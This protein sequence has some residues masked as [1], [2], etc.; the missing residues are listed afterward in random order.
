MGRL[1][2]EQKQKLKQRRSVSDSDWS[3]PLRYLERAERTIGLGVGTLAAATPLGA[4]ANLIPGVRDWIPDVQNIPEAVGSFWEQAR[5]GDWDAGIE[6]YQDELDAGAGYWGLSELAGAFIP[7]GGPALAGAKL[8]SAAPKIGSGFAKFAPVATREAIERA[9]T[10]AATRT[11]QVLRA[12]WEAEE[13]VGRAAVEGITRLIKGKRAAP[14]TAPDELTGLFPDEEGP[15]IFAPA[16]QRDPIRRPPRGEEIP[17]LEGTFPEGTRLT[18]EGIVLDAEGFP[19]GYI[20]E[21][22]NEFIS[23]QVFRGQRDRYGLRGMGP[24]FGYKGPQPGVKNIEQRTDQELL[25]WMESKGMSPRIPGGD[26]KRLAREARADRP[27]KTGKK[28]LL[29]RI[30]FEV[31]RGGLSEDVAEAAEEWIELLPEEYLEDLASSF[32]QMIPTDQE[33][34]VVLGRLNIGQPSLFYGGRGPSILEIGK[35]MSNMADQADRV[36]IHEIVHHLEEYVSSA[37][38]RKLVSAWQKEQ[39]TKGQSVLNKVKEIREKRRRTEEATGK[40]V[41]YTQSEKDIIAQEYRYQGDFAEWFAEVLTDKALRDIY[42]EVPV[43]KNVIE[44]VLAQIKIMAKA[45]RE[46][47]SKVLGRND[48]AEDV[49]Q[50]LMRGDY[51]VEERRFFGRGDLDTDEWFDA[52]ATRNLS[53]DPS[54]IGR[55]SS[56]RGALDPLYRAPITAGARAA[57]TE[58]ARFASSLSGIDTIGASLDEGTA[59]VVD[60]AEW[61]ADIVAARNEAFDTNFEPRDFTTEESFQALKASN[62]QHW[63]VSPVCVNLSAAKAG[64]KLDPNDIAIGKAVVRAIDEIRPPSISLENVPDYTKTTLFKDITDALDRAGYSWDTNVVEAADYGAASTRKRLILRAVLPEAG[65]LPPLPQKTHAFSETGQGVD[66]YETLTDLIQVEIDGGRGLPIS[67]AF[68][69]KTPGQVNDELSRI[70]KTFQRKEGDRLRLNPN[71]PIL[72]MGGSASKGIPSARNAGNP[73]PTLMSTDRAVPRIILPGPGGFSD[74]TVIRVT[75]EMMQRL[76]GIPEGFK[77]PAAPR[78][79]KTT[80]GNGVHGAVTKGFIQPLVDI[81]RAAPQPGRQLGA[82]PRYLKARVEDIA[83]VEPSGRITG[84]IRRGTTLDPEMSQRMRATLGQ[85]S[86]LSRWDKAKN[87]FLE[88]GGK[89]P[90]TAARTGA[91]KA[92]M[93]TKREIEQQITSHASRVTATVRNGKRVFGAL[94]ENGRILDPA[95]YKQANVVLAE[96]GE[97]YYLSTINRPTIQ[98]VAARLPTY[99]SVMNEEQLQFMEL[100]REIFETGTTKTTR[101]IQM[102]MPGWNAVLRETLNF[103][104]RRVRPDIEPG[105]FYLTRGSAD[106]P[107]GARSYNDLLEA[108]KPKPKRLNKRT[109]EENPA[110]APSMDEAIRMGVK[111]NSLEDSLAEQIAHVGTQVADVNLSKLIRL[112]LKQTPKALKKHR[113]KDVVPGGMKNLQVGYVDDELADALR[114]ATQ[115]GKLAKVTSKLGAIREVNYIYRAFKATADFSAI[116][117]HG[118]FAAFRR[119]NEWKN[120]ALISL[121]AAVAPDSVGVVD[122][123]V[124]NA[125]EEALAKGLPTSDIWASARLHLGGSGTEYSLPRLQELAERGPKAVKAAAGL[126]DRFNRSFGIFGDSLRIGW[127]NKL[128]KEELDRGFSLEEIWSSGKME[129]IANVVNKLTGYS[130]QRFGGDVGDLLLFAPRFFQARF[131]TYGQVLES[132]GRFATGRRQTIS[133]REAFQ[134]VLW[135]LGTAAFMTEFINHL[136]GHE[137]DRRPWVNGR[138]NPN[139]YRIR[140][141]GRDFSLFGPSIGFFQAIA[142]VA[143]GHPDRAL[144]SLGSGASRIFWDNFITGRTFTGEEAFITDDPEGGKKIGRWNYWLE[145]MIP[146][147]PAQFLP[148]IG[149]GLKGIPGSIRQLQGEETDAP[150]GLDPLRKTAGAF[151]A[152]G[153]EVFGGPASEYSYMDRRDEYAKDAHQVPY[154]SLSGEQKTTVDEK[155]KKDFGLEYRGRSAEDYKKLDEIDQTFLREI[156]LVA[157]KYLYGSVLAEEGWDIKT[158]REETSRLKSDRWREREKINERLYPGEREEEVFEIGSPEYNAQQYGKAFET[159]TDNKG[160]LDFDLLNKL[161]GELWSTLDR[162]QGKRLLDDIRLIEKSSQFPAKIAKM[163]NAQRYAGVVKLNIDGMNIRYW[164]IEDLPQVR[165]EIARVAG[166]SLAE[167]AEYFEAPYTLREDR[168][169]PGEK[170]A[171]LHAAVL[172]AKGDDGIIGQKQANFLKTAAKQKPGWVYG[173]I[174][175]GYDFT[176]IKGVKFALRKQMEDDGKNLPELDYENLLLGELTR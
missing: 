46:F 123:F 22:T 112:T 69:S 18:D 42:M 174:E 127:A 30:D 79:A 52:A 149:E 90:L 59:K 118:A 71:E 169:E 62:P 6:A 26:P 44:K 96:G 23:P 111:Y 4:V 50:K 91:V 105:G 36:I 128:L 115:P 65:Q 165:Q 70:M 78:L 17:G 143:T 37:D 75:P 54:D 146:I 7:T 140:Y 148:S 81:H 43:Y 131:E 89:A 13:A 92:G 107:Q 132:A 34:T 141:G 57:T 66:W 47:I 60:Q 21:S 152:A 150:K 124:K 136:N 142:N 151:L 61:N 159:A 126:F 86:T 1:S 68:R 168:S 56:T 5:Q 64:R 116:G 85:Q 80:L 173:M 119:P 166:V 49:Y 19:L 135:T 134:T 93:K 160:R 122:M 11:G 33:G 94:D 104:P 87:V 175:G 120:A 9:G 125:D 156:N 97:I 139:F 106:L 162:V 32:H 158:A 41:S 35:R 14:T 24:E 29:S 88:W 103:D 73:A 76:M 147:A 176:G 163:S 95:F 10:T 31:R 67:A 12:P 20:D 121:K 133:S 39:K 72:T 129:D 172:S 100:L 84:D 113:I 38:A 77:V 3:A 8:I 58:Q 55:V 45:T 138:P 16:P 167:V 74:A 15:S 108:L 53:V 63:H 157:G 154:D 164:E 101:G 145:T 2:P 155:I 109:V 161:H 170:W 99:R 27:I 171:T 130:A 102:D 110:K 144:R 137:T 48:V 117:I 28:A 153:T 51:P 83:D 25:S 98:D 82:E 114:K 40:G